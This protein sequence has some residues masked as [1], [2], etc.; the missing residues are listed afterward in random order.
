MKWSTRA[1][2]TQAV[3]GETKFNRSEIFGGRTSKRIEQS[4]PNDVWN[5]SDAIVFQEKIHVC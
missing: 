1:K 3:R 5:E 2:Q 4:K